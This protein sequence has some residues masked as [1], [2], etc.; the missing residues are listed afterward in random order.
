MKSK[1]DLKQAGPPRTK[2]RCCAAAEDHDCSRLRPRMKVYKDVCCEVRFGLQRQRR[3]FAVE[4]D[5][6]EDEGVEVAVEV[7][8]S[9]AVSNKDWGGLGRRT[10]GS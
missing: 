4:G 5:E 1:N 9:G 7:Y 6:A 8:A 2:D 10:V 3:S